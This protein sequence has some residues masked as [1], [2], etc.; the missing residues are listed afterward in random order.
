MIR[1][2]NL[3]NTFDYSEG[4]KAAA[5]RVLVELVNLFDEYRDEI[6]IVG[7]WVPD[8]MFPGEGHVGSV[9]VDVL[10][11]HT[12]LKDSGYL[13]MSKIL[14]RN[15]YTEHPEKYFSFIKQ[16]NID[17][18]LYDVDVDILAG[19]NVWRYADKEKKP[20]RSGHKGVEGNRWKFCV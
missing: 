4:Q 2:E 12:R 18:V 20:A 11:N 8:L 6:R 16:V 15:G 5:H 17:G 7:G 3:R 1:D 19:W 14:L 9:D 10:I 13:T